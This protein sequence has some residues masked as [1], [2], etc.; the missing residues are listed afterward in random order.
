MGVSEG[1]KDQTIWRLMLV[2][3]VIAVGLGLGRALLFSGPMTESRRL[4]DLA[5]AHRFDVVLYLTMG[6]PFLLLG[7]GV[8]VAL[9]GKSCP[10]C[11][12]RPLFYRGKARVE[13]FPVTLLT[14]P[15]CRGRY[16]LGES[17]VDADA[18]GLGALF[19]DLA[20]PVL[21]ASELEPEERMEPT[22]PGLLLKG[23]RQVRGTENW[24]ALMG[25]RKGRRPSPPIE[26]PPTPEEAQVAERFDA[27]VAHQRQ[28]KAQRPSDGDDVK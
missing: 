28:R 11:G 25:P 1:P 22:V 26:A 3:A 8:L 16:V 20:G 10:R 19:E 14:C 7:W 23:Q 18:H 17:L 4:L 13:D 21:D 6:V 27:L 24:A 12:R 9:R 2:V 5:N 15:K